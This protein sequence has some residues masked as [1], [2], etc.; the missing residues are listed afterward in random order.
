MFSSLSLQR[1]V[2]DSLHVGNYLRDHKARADPPNSDACPYHPKPVPL[3]SPLPA[4]I[5]KA[6][7][8]L[9]ESFK[10]FVFNETVAVSLYAH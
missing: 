2:H 5:S 10:I 7:T 9:T 1:P 4:N 6:I 8:N 3:P